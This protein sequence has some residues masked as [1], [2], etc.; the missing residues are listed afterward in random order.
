M[1][2]KILFILALYTVNIFVFAQY[3]SGT[4]FPVGT[5][6]VSVKLETTPSLVTL[7]L[8]GP[9]NCYLG[10]GAGDAGM[11][12]GA[13]GFIYNSAS[14]TDYTFNGIGNTPS[15]DAIQDWTITSNTVSGSTRTIV[16]TRSLTGSAGDTPIPNAA[17]NLDVFVARGNETMNLS[18]HGGA[19]RDYATLPMSLDPTLAT[20]EVKTDPTKYVMY[21]NPTIETVHFKNIDLIKSID[22]YETTGR[23]VKTLK[24]K[25]GYIDVSDLKQGNYYLEITLKDGTLTYEKLIKQ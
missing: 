21:P 8:A 24:W 12:T 10:L 11:A 20:G 23:K 25:E 9:S 4:L 3:S 14:T 2:R 6:G 1:K 18:Y 17:G 7:T 5:T 15:A 13:D 19:N 22:V 16:A